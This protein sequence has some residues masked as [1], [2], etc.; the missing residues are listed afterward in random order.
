MPTNDLWIAAPALQHDLV[1]YA[2]DEHFD[3]LPQLLRV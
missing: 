3:H 1:L 2:R